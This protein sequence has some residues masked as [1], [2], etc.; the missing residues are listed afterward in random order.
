MI[1]FKVIPDGGERFDLTADSRDVLVWERTAKGKVRSV[2]ELVE[3]KSFVE[4]YRLAHIAAKR[5]GV[6]DGDLAEF[7]ATHALEV[8]D[9]DDGEDPTR[10]AP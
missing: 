9:D 4:F 2:G 5:Q 6:F 7:E 10:P 3:S 8:G 1:D